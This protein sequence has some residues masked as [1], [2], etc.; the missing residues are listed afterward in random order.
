MNFSAKIRAARAALGWTQGYL[1]EVS[2]V[3]TDTLQNIEGGSTPTI[4]T[5]EKIVRALTK[6][7]V[8]FSNDGFSMPDATAMQLNGKDWFL[9]VLEDAYQVVQSYRN[10]EILIFGSDHRVST[11][12]VIEGFRKLLTIGASMREIGEEGNTYIMSDIKQFRWV[13]TEHYKNTVTMIYGDRVVTDFSTHG[14]LIKNKDWAAAERHKFELIWA[15][16]IPV[17]EKSTADVRY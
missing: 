11:K 16:A 14:M 5:Q 15:N 13:P 10:K 2:G 9:D 8:V 6:N 4:R 3:S 12:Q 17:K 7:G 1:A